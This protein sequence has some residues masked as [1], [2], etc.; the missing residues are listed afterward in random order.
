MTA[1]RS[2][3]LNVH[4]F[5]SPENSSSSSACQSIWHCVVDT[6]VV[7]LS[8]FGISLENAKTLCV[9]EMINLEG[10]V[11]VT[12][13]CPYPQRPGRTGIAGRSSYVPFFF[14]FQ[15]PPRKK[16]RNSLHDR[17]Y[18]YLLVLSLFETAIV[19]ST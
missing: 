18:G 15:K 11:P 12:L 7:W 14:F 8:L 19:S 5:R 6:R 16:C 1:N 17:Y 10:Q 2:S 3:V 9:V 4:H 13:R